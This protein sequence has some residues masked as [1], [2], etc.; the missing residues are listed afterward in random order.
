MGI[1]KNDDRKMFKLPRYEMKLLFFDT[2]TNGLP[3]RRNAL[4]SDTSNWPRVVQVAWEL[5]EYDAGNYNQIEQ[6][7]F[8][9]RMPGD[10]CWDAESS[11][12][13]GINAE[14]SEREGTP[15]EIVLDA[16]QK[17]AL[18]CD[19]LIAHNMAFDNPI[20][21]CEYVRLF[22]DISWWPKKT[23]CT[24][25]NTKSLLKLPSKFPKPHDLYKFPKLQELYAYLF[26]ASHSLQFHSA[27]VDVSCLV[28]CYMELVHRKYIM[29]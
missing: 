13:H 29:L 1:G 8:I 19:V 18:K 2:E 7:A 3:K 12:I 25:E 22:R 24:M 26:P 6:Q 11:A 9:V 14:R 4:V 5:W 23:Y 10:L 28:R 20:L 17:V 21:Q 15:G 27:D 16:F